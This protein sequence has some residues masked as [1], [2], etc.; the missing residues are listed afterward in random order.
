MNQ[1]GYIEPEVDEILLEFEAMGRLGKFG[2]IGYIGQR[3]FARPNFK[4]SPAVAHDLCDGPVGCAIGSLWLSGGVP[5]VISEDGNGVISLTDLPGTSQEARPGFLEDKPNLSEALAMLEDVARAWVVTFEN[6][7]RD[8][9][10]DSYSW[11]GRGSTFTSPLEHYFEEV[12]PAM[13][14]IDK[15]VDEEA[16]QKDA[17]EFAAIPRVRAYTN[18]QM[19]AIAVET[20]RRNFPGAVR[21]PLFERLRGREAVA[22]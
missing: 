13:L 3:L 14:R 21:R 5:L 2:R 7:W 12:I 4:R 18:Q 9:V 6:E 16:F 11:Y 1:C 10:P 19:H 17:E 15:V 20:L 8:R 22:A